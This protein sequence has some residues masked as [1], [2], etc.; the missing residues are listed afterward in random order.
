M[1][2]ILEVRNHMEINEWIKIDHKGNYPD[3]EDFKTDDFIHSISNVFGNLDMEHEII[4]ELKRVKDRD[5][6][7]AKKI[8]D[9][10]A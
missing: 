5:W 9:E 6:E 3:F 2:T 10:M 7:Q 4:I 8:G 1:K